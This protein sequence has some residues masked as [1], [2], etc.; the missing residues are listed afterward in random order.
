MR[1]SHTPTLLL[2]A[3]SLCVCGIRFEMTQRETVSIR[4]SLKELSFVVDDLNRVPDFERLQRS[5]VVIS[6]EYGGF[7]S[8]VFIS[9]DGLILTAGHVADG[10]AEKIILSDSIEYSI[11][12]QWN[13]S[14]YDV[15]FVRIDV[16]DICEAVYFL[17]LA[18]STPRIGKTV[19]LCGAPYEKKLFSTITK[20]VV[21]SIDRDV[22]DWI[23]TIQVD[24]EGAPGSSGGPLVDSN[25]RM[26]GICVGGPNP[27]GG[28]IVCESLEHIREGLERYENA[29]P[30]HN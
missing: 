25:G 2:I 15:G 12:D 3:A 18:E 5:T 17:N 1:K 23:E 28:V 27:G 11:I 10:R 20:G 24:A 4:K 30:S 8:G 19:Y 13:D 21:S 29:C 22:H 6:D 16:N 14:E 26:I 7:G 9:E